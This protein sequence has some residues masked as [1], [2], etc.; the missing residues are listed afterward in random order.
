MSDITMC[1]G[2]DCP[3]KGS[4]QR[5]NDNPNKIKQS[6]FIKPPYSFLKKNCDMYWEIK[7]TEFKTL[8]EIFKK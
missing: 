6:Y 5:Y 2:K 4:C 7:K 3:L 1:E 8:K